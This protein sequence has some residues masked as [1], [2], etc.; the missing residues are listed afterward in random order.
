MV[1]V[2]SGPLCCA[3]ARFDGFAGGRDGALLRPSLNRTPPAH[4]G[5]RGW[6]WTLPVVPGVFGCTESTL[7]ISCEGLYEGA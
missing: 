7:A 2:L 4:I 3:V 6:P 5:S 1:A